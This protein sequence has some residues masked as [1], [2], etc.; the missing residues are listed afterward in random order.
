[1]GGSS[2]VNV[3]PRPPSASGLGITFHPLMLYP[4]RPRPCWSA[5]VVTNCRRE[6]ETGGDLAQRK[7]NYG[8]RPYDFCF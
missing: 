2:P 7:R 3:I 8:E 4:V 5:L 1:M 6:S